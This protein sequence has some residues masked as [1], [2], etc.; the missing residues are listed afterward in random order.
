MRERGKS[1]TESAALGRHRRGA[2][3]VRVH[4]RRRRRGS[5]INVDGVPHLISADCV[6]APA[7]P[8]ALVRARLVQR[9]G[10]AGQR[11]PCPRPR[12]AR[13]AAL[14]HLLRANSAPAHWKLAA[15]DAPR[16][17]PPGGLDRRRLRRLLPRVGGGAA[18]PDAARRDRSGGGSDRRARRPARALRVRP[19]GPLTPARRGPSATLWRAWRPDVRCPPR[20]RRARRPPRAARARRGVPRRVPRAVRRRRDRRARPRAAASVR[21]LG[22]RGHR[23]AHGLPAAVRGAAARVGDDRRAARARADDPLGVR[24]LRR[25]PR[26]GSRSRRASSPFLVLRAVQGAANA[27]TSP[28]LLATLAE[29]TP[30]GAARAQH[31]HVRRRADRRARDG[32]AVRRAAR[33]DRAAARVR[34][35]GRWSRCCS[36]PRRCPARAGALRETRARLR[37]AFNAP[38]DDDRDRRLPRLPGDQRRELPRR[39]ARGRQLR[40]RRDG[41]RTAARRLRVRGIARRAAGGRARRPHRL[42]ADRG[43]RR[44][45]LRGDARAARPRGSVGAA[46]ALLAR[47]RRRVV[48]G[49]GRPEHARRPERPRESRR[50]DLGRRRVQVRRATPSPRRSGCRCT[51]RATSSPSPPRPS[52]APRSCWS[53]GTLGGPRRIVVAAA[54]RA[55]RGRRRTH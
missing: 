12:S 16:R 25:R 48:V 34:G 43:V 1:P 33:R 2:L 23:R 50:R 37:D 6:R 22:G 39:A 3:A 4:P 47:R 44:A 5:W 49:L 45:A 29:A 40:P 19:P 32:A 46:G 53:C 24:R 18:R 15:V 7:R 11:A 41:A 52:S 17:R 13:S 26:S 51:S 27:F 55:R 31:G 36:P 30:R 35:A 8:G 10:G 9:L 42:A 38:L 21:R 54:D 20:E 14:S 28:L